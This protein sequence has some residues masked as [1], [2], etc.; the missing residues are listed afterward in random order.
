AYM[1]VLRSPHAHARLVNVDVSAALGQPGVIVALA[2]ADLGPNPPRLP[3][4]VP[5]KNL[6]PRMPFPL[7]IGKVR[8]VGEPVALVVAE[9]TYQA[10]DALEHIRV[11]YEELPVVLDPEAALEPGAP[12]L[13][14]EGEDNV[15]A[16]ISQYIGDP[17]R[18]FAEAEVVLR[19]TF[20]HGRLSGQP[21]ET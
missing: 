9:S 14:D 7:A 12:L 11:E 6:R 1:A 20:R 16:E 18:A 3:M 8:H 15:A 2:G 17:D 19:H 5:H 10:E 4:L 13:H 21:L